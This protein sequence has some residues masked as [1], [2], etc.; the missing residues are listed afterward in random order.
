MGAKIFENYAFGTDAKS[1]FN[2]VHQQEATEHGY[3]RYSGTIAT[4]H[5]FY[6]AADK[7]LTAKAAASKM[8][9]DL[10][11]PDSPANDK[12]GPAACLEV[13]IP[14]E[15]REKLKQALGGEGDHVY[16]FY[17]WASD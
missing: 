14:D 17:G 2:S 10:D 5:D 3:G 13:T 8:A 6:M 1:A 12:W 16:M 7:P 4:K 11:D 9:E 15:R